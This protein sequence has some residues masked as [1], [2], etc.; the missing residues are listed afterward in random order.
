MHV[1]GIVS[2]TQPTELLAAPG[3]VHVLAAALLLNEV[4]ALGTRLGHKQLLEVG[5]RFGLQGEKV[6]E[7]FPP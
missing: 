2:Q 7:L 6:G 4:A 5:S 3:A 1:G